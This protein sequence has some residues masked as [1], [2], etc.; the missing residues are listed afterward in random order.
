MFAKDFLFK[1][2][3][4]VA[5]LCGLRSLQCF[6]VFCVFHF[7]LQLIVLSLRLLCFKHPSVVK[8]SGIYLSSHSFY[9]MLRL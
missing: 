7:F 1:K 9:P 2:L 5:T 3:L 6:F 8:S 4:A